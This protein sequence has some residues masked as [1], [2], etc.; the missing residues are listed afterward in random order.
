MDW[1]F[2][3]IRNFLL[4]WVPGWAWFIVA[5]VVLGWVWRT[6]GWQGYLARP[7]PSSPLV[8]I[9]RAGA[10]AAPKNLPRRACP[11]KAEVVSSTLA[12]CANN[13]NGVAFFFLA[14]RQTVSPYFHRSRQLW[15]R[16]RGVGQSRNTEREWNWQ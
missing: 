2:G 11:P 3:T 10:I 5:M 1:L 15:S 8:P 13:F 14:N 12:G 4:A 6:F 9:G 16:S 7:S